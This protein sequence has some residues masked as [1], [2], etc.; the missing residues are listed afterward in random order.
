MYSH[1]WFKRPCKS[2]IKTTIT[3]TMTL[4]LSA[5]PALDAQMVTQMKINERE[6]VCTAI[7]AFVGVIALLWSNICV[8]IKP[9]SVWV[10]YILWS[11]FHTVKAHISMCLWKGNALAEIK[12]LPFRFPAVENM[13]FK[14]DVKKQILYVIHGSFW[15]YLLPTFF[16]QVSWTFHPGCYW[17]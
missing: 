17:L 1:V 11:L 9:L 3:H 14:S 4:S 6:L 5:A 2:L 8:E 13:L 15:C 10:T 7:T 12:M 16:K